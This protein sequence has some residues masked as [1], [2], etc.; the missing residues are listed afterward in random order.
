MTNNYEWYPGHMTAAIRMMR[1]S[2]SQVDLV[3]ETAD[4][5]IPQASRNPDI[6]DLCR[7][8]ARLLVLC[9]ADLSDP[10]ALKTWTAHYRREG[11]TV[12]AVNARSAGS[13]KA[14]L[15][16]VN[17][18]SREKR[19]RNARRGIKNQAI[20]ALV[21]GIPNVGKSTIINLLAGRSAAKT[22]N[23]PGVTRGEQWIQAGSGLQLL[24]SPGILWP[25]IG[26]PD[27]GEML[28][29]IGSMND[30]NL[31]ETA[32]ACA[33]IRR[34]EQYYPDA[35]P[36]RYFSATNVRA[37]RSS[38]RPENDPVFPPAGHAD[39]TYEVLERIAT[40]RGCIGEGGKLLVSRAAQI[41]LD[42]FRSGKLGGI[43][44]E[45]MAG[46]NDDSMNSMGKE[47]A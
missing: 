35:V 32:L 36:Q 37:D 44:L 13:K 11:L 7:N 4:A 6:D 3:I 38:K 9:K 27:A 24:D 47:E 30:D 33:L 34:L 21:A 22:G 29:L 43:L 26:D 16:A 23:K 14:L 19:E 25:K 39:E 8:K 12:T 46:N 45:R 20:R 1:E 40:V 5:R 15:N 10:N 42:D 17:E 41:L 28:A 18:A 2:L 31:D